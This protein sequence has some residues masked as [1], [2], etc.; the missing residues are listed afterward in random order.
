MDAIER[1]LSEF[2]PD[3]PQPTPIHGWPQAPNVNFMDSTLQPMEFRGISQHQSMITHMSNASPC[4]QSQPRWGSP[5]RYDSI[6]S[7]NDELIFQSGFGVK[8]QDL[9]ASG[10]IFGDS[11]QISVVSSAK[12]STGD[13]ATSST[14]D[15]SSK[16]SLR[17]PR[18]KKPPVKKKRRISD[19]AGTGVGLAQGSTAQADGMLPVDDGV[20]EPPSKRTRGRALLCQ[21]PTFISS[22]SRL[23]KLVRVSGDTK[24]VATCDDE[25]R[26]FLGEVAQIKETFT[27]TSGISD[28]H[29]R[30]DMMITMLEQLIEGEREFNVRSPAVNANDFTMVAQSHTELRQ[31]FQQLVWASALHMIADDSRRVAAIAAYNDSV[32]RKANQSA[33]TNITESNNLIDKTAEEDSVV[34]KGTTLGT[35]RYRPGAVNKVCELIIEQIMVILTLLRQLQQEERL[36]KTRMESFK[37][38]ITADFAKRN[39]VIPDS[40]FGYVARLYGSGLLIASS[41]SATSTPQVLMIPLTPWDTYT[42]RV[43]RSLNLCALWHRSIVESMVSEADYIGSVLTDWRNCPIPPFRPPGKQKG[44][45]GP[46]GKRGKNLAGLQRSALVSHWRPSFGS[47]ISLDDPDVLSAIVDQTQLSAHAPANNPLQSR[48]PVPTPAVSSSMAQVQIGTPVRR[49]MH[50]CARAFLMGTPYA[51]IPSYLEPNAV[52]LLSISQAFEKIMQH[53]SLTVVTVVYPSLGLL[54]FAKSIQEIVLSI[55]QLTGLPHPESRPSLD[56]LLRTGVFDAGMDKREQLELLDPQAQFETAFGINLTDLHNISMTYEPTVALRPQTPLIIAYR[57]LHLATKLLRDALHQMVSF[58]NV[59]I[60]TEF[61]QGMQSAVNRYA[62]DKFNEN[63]VAHDGFLARMVLSMTPISMAAAMGEQELARL[64]WPI[65]WSNGETVFIRSAVKPIVIESGRRHASLGPAKRPYECSVWPEGLQPIPLHLAVQRGLTR[66]R[67][68]FRRKSWDA[69]KAKLLI[70]LFEMNIIDAL[71]SLETNEVVRANYA[72]RKAALEQLN[73]RACKQAQS[74]FPTKILP[75]KETVLAALDE[76]SNQTV[77]EEEVKEKESTNPATTA[78]AII[79]EFADMNLD[80]P[81]GDVDD[82]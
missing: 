55:N 60:E 11:V 10:C 56:A 28:E 35:Y 20:T 6:D 47:T 29:S 63:A 13:I 33:A 3:V 57:G 4:L 30:V 16:K 32:A 40:W 73:E 21:L 70:F 66:H 50:M 76:L 26:L 48:F 43:E 8:T 7:W 54:P 61:N 41:L 51:R 79:A 75:T 38:Q 65:A 27:D 31:L 1:Y 74:G 44:A 62:L 64:T 68:H 17:T 19:N 45:T 49:L 81:D 9:S 69:M 53:P 22:C 71:L 24:S 46:L 39:W 25:Y 52:G 42:E 18:T 67:E 78:A 14:S 80:D 82:M 59:L 12:V 36:W 37:L 34:P 72:A 15:T 58:V 2:E 23:G 77:S 5:P